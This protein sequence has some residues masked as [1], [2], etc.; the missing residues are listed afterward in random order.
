MLEKNAGYGDNFEYLEDICTYMSALA[1]V[2]I[3]EADTA[4]ESSTDSLR[5][6]LLELQSGLE[7][8][9]EVTFDLGEVEIPLETI[10]RELNLS[11]T[12]KNILALL[13]CCS[14]AISLES[15]ITELSDSRGVD[16]KMVLDLFSD[17]VRERV[18]VR[19][20]LSSSEK[21]ISKGLLHMKCNKVKQSEQAF[22]RNELELS[23]RILSRI[24]GED[25]E[26]EILAPYIELL[27]PTV[28]I[29]DLILPAELKETALNLV[30]D[31][32]G[33]FRLWK[34]WG[35]EEIRSFGG[36]TILLFTGPEGSGRRTLA[37]AL[38]GEVGS[39]CIQVRMDRI[40][41]ESSSSEEICREIFIEAQYLNAIPVI[42]GADGLFSDRNVAEL[43]AFRKSLKGFQGITILTAEK[44]QNIGEAFDNC[45]IQEIELP[46]PEAEQREK[47]WNRLI[48]EGAP[49][50]DDVDIKRMAGDFELT[51]GCIQ[52]TI[53][54][55]SI[56]S[57]GRKSQRITHDDLVSSANSQIEIRA[58]ERDGGRG[59]RI[60]FRRLSENEGTD[61][62]DTSRSSVFMKD[63]I[64]PVRV[65]RQVQDIIKAAEQQTKVFD[66]WGFGSGTGSERSISVLF[67]GESGTGKT[68]TAEA[69]AS[70]LN[71]KLCTV[72]GSSLIS[73][74]V[75]ESEKNIVRVFREADEN[76]LIFF[77][78]ADSIF[79]SRI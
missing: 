43:T 76:V 59:R 37:M 12:E 65:E 7:S 69:V 48:P 63:V 6:R 25:V 56:T 35:F 1:D 23:S 5:S 39:K 9:V 33:H 11:G 4:S 52:K 64:L 3:A 32:E 13:A 26:N 49:L 75:G 27:E 38:A 57:L 36:N 71:R 19:K 17:S 21:L 20:M 72:R 61:L 15:R 28:R 62:F 60:P 47:L 40:L 79:T 30:R 66:E 78:E 70:E 22:L 42:T 68:L 45:V 51:A 74:W 14:P 24:I 58:L 46:L 55:A 8:K 44:V 53:I 67:Q 50:G 29:D 16:V 73:K 41:N 77:D 34:E 31:R 18:A 10:Q 54:N 2:R